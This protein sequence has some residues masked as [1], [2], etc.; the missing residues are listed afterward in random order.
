[1][2]SK[3]NYTIV[4]LFVVILTTAM[5]SF[6]YWLTKSYGV[7]VYD[8]YYVHLTESV[9]G[10]NIDAAVKYR[11]V[12]VGTVTNIGINPENPEEVRLALEINR[13][14]HIKTDTTAAIS[15]YGITGLAFIELK[16]MDKNAPLLKVVDDTV[17]VIPSRPSA[18]KRIDQSLSQLAEKSA[19][20]LDNI[21][22]LFGDKNLKN[23]EDLLIESKG[24]V[25][26]LRSQLDGMQTLMDKGLEMESKIISAADK[27]GEASTSI[28]LLADNLE[29]NTTGISQ[30]MS[31][32]MRDSFS[33][34]T[35][36]LSDLDILTISL[37]STINDIKTSPG[38]LLF[39]RTQTL[40]GPG[41][42]GYHEK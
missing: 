23:I 32:G 3:L 30:E 42:E 21:N 2:E 34:L 7:Q 12:D 41:E 8:T 18:I 37:Q 38:D 6:A 27:V 39:K 17:P 35:Q 19:K 15:Y 1:M 36:L 20:T 28:K 25:T 13:D 29:K 11:G 40:P 33:A 14:T 31:T 22:R 16:G 4:G 10:L 5:L 24:L 9:A 26:D